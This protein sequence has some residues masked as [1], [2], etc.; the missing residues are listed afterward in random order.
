MKRFSALI[1]A[2]CLMLCACSSGEPAATEAPA[3]EAP[4][5]T[6]APATEAPATEAP[7][8]EAPTEA[9]A[10]EA[11]TEAPVVYRNPLTGEVMDQPLET[12]IFSLSV[13]NTHDALPQYGISKADV[14]WEIYVNGYV[15]RLLAMFTDVDSVEAIGSIRSQRYPFTDLAQSYDAIACSAG[16]SDAVMNDVKRSGVDY[17]NVDTGDE[18][19]YSYRDKARIRSGFAEY[20]SLF[21][22]GNGLKDLAAKKGIDVTAD[23][24]KTYGMNFSENVQLNGDTAEKISITFRLGGSN[25]NTTMTYDQATGEYLFAQ[26]G[27]AIVDGY[28]DNAAVSFKNVFILWV[29]TTTDGDGYHISKILGSGKGYFACNGQLIPILWNR[30]NDDSPFTFTL[31]DGT[32]LEQ[33]IGSSYIGFIPQKSSVAWE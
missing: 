30:A 23:P 18:T 24:N 5:V 20:H 26:Y 9:P 4:V 17:M 3:T 14:I 15:T 21:A 16:G 10:T 28:Y 32:A 8:T 6:E 12:R 25:K 7:A 1:L 13:G 11:P 22:K 27:K 33:G 19:S 2:L 29:D 31:E